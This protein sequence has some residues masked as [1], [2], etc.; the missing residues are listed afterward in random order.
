[1]LNLKVDLGA[2]AYPIYIGH[3]ILSQLGEMIQLYG[4]A[5]QAV[6]ITD[7]QVHALYAE[8]MQNALSGHLALA[9]EIVVPSGEKSKSIA[10]IEKILTRMLQK[11]C[12]RRVLVLAFG[13]GV[14]GD[15][16]GFAASIYKRGVPYLQVPT[17]LLAQVDSS[18][19]GKTGINHPLGKNMIG[20]FYQPKMVW[21]DLALLQTLP[22][23]EILCGL[24]EVI[25]HGIIRDTKLFGSIEKHLESILALDSE[26]MTEIVKRCCEIKADVVARDERET[27]LRMVLN[28]GHTVGHAIES[29]LGYKHIAHGEAVLLGMLAEAKMATILAILSQTDF[30]RIHALVSRF[31]LFRKLGRLSLTE[32]VDRMRSDKK[33][34]DG[35]IRF[36]LP[37]RIGDVK[38]VDTVTVDAVEQGLHFLLSQ[39]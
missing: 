38:I 2:Q 25:K 22:Q 39:S 12:D 23:R 20:T 31:D 32:I 5:K 29:A 1:M 15:L 35:K 11:Q 19:G 34:L 26:R 30:D 18:V 28:F 7:D 36:V 37:T 6:V 13:G 17:T 4:L 8:Q 14:V 16:A 33:V 27:G 21:M 9:E 24:G 3:G 10:A